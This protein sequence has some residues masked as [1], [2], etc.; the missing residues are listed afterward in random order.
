MAV[1]FPD[2]PINGQTFTTGS[3]SYVYNASKGT[4]DLVTT[5]APVM[6]TGKVIAMSIVFGG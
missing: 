6:T 1:N 3:V 5:T 2:T 4:W